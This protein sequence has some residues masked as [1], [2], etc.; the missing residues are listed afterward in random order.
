[1]ENTKHF[2]NPFL[3]IF[4]TSAPENLKGMQIKSVF[5][6]ESLR[7]RYNLILLQLSE[8]TWRNEFS[9]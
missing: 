1:M 2:Q 8:M 7:I 3:L 5:K 9:Y 6:G 4:V